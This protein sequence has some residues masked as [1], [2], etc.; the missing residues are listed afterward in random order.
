MG[1]TVEELWFNSWHGQSFPFLQSV[2]ISSGP[3]SHSEDSEGSFS[4]GWQLCCEA[5][6]SLPSSA[7]FKNVWIYTSTIYIY[8]Y[9]YIYIPNALVS[10]YMFRCTVNCDVLDTLYMMFIMS[11]IFKQK[12]PPTLCCSHLSCG[13]WVYLYMKYFIPVSY[14][15]D[16]LLCL[17]LSENI[18]HP[19]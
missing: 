11:V 7:K 12:L 6:H 2:Q 17:S 8:I 19:C 10:S 16:R 1:W 14:V 13:L 5:D 9:I 18:V 3:A 4:G 15:E